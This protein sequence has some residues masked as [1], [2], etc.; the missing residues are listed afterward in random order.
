MKRHDVTERPILFNGQMVPPVLA[1]I[2]TQT[3]RVVKPR[4]LEWMDEHQGLR[5]QSNVDRC[6]YGK[7]M[8]RLW[9]RE[10]W[11]AHTTFD[12]LPPREIPQSHVWYMADEGYK[13]QSRFRQAMFMPRWASRITL[14][15]TDVRVERLQ[16]ISEVDAI[17][18]GVRSNRDTLAETG[19]A[20][21]RDAYRYLWKS[22][23]GPGSWDLNPWVWAITFRR[24]KP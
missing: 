9:V 14:E 18:E 5:E 1:D 23:N 3:R 2:K 16:D 24:I 17:A 11:K 10:A 21:A 6:P 22:I 19:H 7:P 12:H 15:I 4:D 20:T 13:A 8:D